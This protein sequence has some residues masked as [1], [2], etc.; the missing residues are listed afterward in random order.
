MRQWDG[1]LASWPAGRVGPNS[2]LECTT[3]VRTRHESKN[4]W[5]DS[6]M[7][8]ES[9]NPVG[10]NPIENPVCSYN[11][12]KE[13]KTTQ[14]NTASESGGWVRTQARSLEEGACST[15]EKRMET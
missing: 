12:T 9:E 11:E 10:K 7:K 13:N 6:G 15:A 4:L 14:R 5:A 8:L 1:M 2:R 3:L